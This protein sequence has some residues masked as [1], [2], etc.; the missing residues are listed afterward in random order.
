MKK[1][2]GF[3]KS[4]LIFFYTKAHGCGHDGIFVGCLNDMVE[5]MH[6]LVC[7]AEKPVRPI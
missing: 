1:T 4:V 2:N 6:W 7:I 3:E 5:D